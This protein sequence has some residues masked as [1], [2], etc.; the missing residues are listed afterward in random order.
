MPA[1]LTAHL[2]EHAAAS[3]LL[4]D[5]ECVRIGRGAECG[6][7]LEHPS[8]SRAHAELRFEAGSWRLIDLGS[9][10][11][12]HVDGAAIN[13]VELGRDGWLRFGDVYCEFARLSDE[14]VAASERHQHARRTRATALTAG[15]QRASGFGDLLEGSLRAVIELARCERGF[16]LLD[17]DGDYVV[18]AQHALDAGRELRGF[19]GSIGAV[20]RALRE[21][22]A[23]VVND[24]GGEAWLAQRASVIAGAL[25]ALV[26]L[27]L[28]DGDDALGAIY[29]DRRGAGEAI[30]TL[31]LELLQAFAERAAV[32][33]AARRASDALDARALPRWRHI[34]GP[35]VEL[36]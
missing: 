29:A 35:E 36:R 11:G 9:K 19:T 13:D 15:L 30:T 26:C 2:H 20:E 33:I 22:R 10:N 34:A 4:A 28:L 18:R 5:G 23:V 27:P 7:Q 3:R 1:R 14:E 21:R 17:D 31:D 25:S 24:I 32:Y 16:L 12:T 6:L 8:I